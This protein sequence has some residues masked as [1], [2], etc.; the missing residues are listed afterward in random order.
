[1]K[2]EEAIKPFSD[3]DKDFNLWLLLD[4]ARYALYRARELELL[5]YGMT[6]EQSQILF[7][8]HGLKENATPG[9]IAR[10]TLL[11]PHTISGI[12]NR[13]E[14]KGLLKKTKDLNR[15]NQI[16]VSI[17]EKGLEAHQLSSKRGPIHRV[18]SALS[19]G[20]RD[21]L[22]P[23]LVKILAEAGKEPGLSWDAL[24]PLSVSYGIRVLPPY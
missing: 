13:M 7:V 12:V 3:G 19:Q 16:R 21:Q 1:L 5:R 24:T 8:I 4:H 2:K 18:M 9:A 11:K 10:E 20:E 6:P 15:K 22:G 23:L 17:T 14:K